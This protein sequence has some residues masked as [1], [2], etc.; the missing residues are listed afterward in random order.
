MSDPGSTDAD[1]LL[2]IELPHSFRGLDPEAVQSLLTDAVGSLRQAQSREAELRATIASLEAALAVARVDVTAELEDAKRRGRAMVT[3]AQ[4]VRRRV[5]EDLVRRRKVLRR[6]IEQLRVGRERLLE[7]YEVVAQTVQEAT[8]ELGVAVPSAQAAAERAGRRLGPDDDEVT[9]EDLHAMEAEITAA[10]VAGL[11]ILDP[12]TAA[13]RVAAERLATAT[14]AAGDDEEDPDAVPPLV[15]VEATVAA[16]EEM[17]VLGP[18]EGEDAEGPAAEAPPEGEDEPDVGSDV[19][20]DS[21]AAATAETLEE[22]PDESVD[23]SDEVAE[24]DEAPPAA[25]EQVAHQ[26]EALVLP[27]FDRLRS[28]EDEDVATEPAF[29]AAV[30]PIEAPPEE[31]EADPVAVLADD[32]A[33]R[34]RRALADEQNQVLDRLR[35]DR[36]GQLGLDEVL[37]PDDAR[38]VRLATAIEPRLREAVGEQ[39]GAIGAVGDLAARLAGAVADGVRHD[40]EHRVSA[41][42]ADDDGERVDLSRP[43]REAFR[44]WR[45]DRILPLAAEVAAES[46]GG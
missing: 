8:Q 24:T 3:E 32:L 35:Q 14:A 38:V 13:E 42:T 29:A 30:D 21:D 33:R 18:V 41:V 11:P 12:P 27:L 36:R 25:A 22:E 20:D 37:G 45:T 43:V 7:A 9:P 2:D 40:I 34:L 23:G 16:F 4:T 1:R 15:E 44:A 31:E 6:Q 39:G 26:D 17:R 5:L 28:G 46:L 10:R 19:E